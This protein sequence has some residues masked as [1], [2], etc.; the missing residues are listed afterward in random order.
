MH[1]A[2]SSFEEQKDSAKSTPV[3][4]QLPQIALS[5]ADDLA[6]DLVGGKM[7]MLKRVKLNCAN[8]AS[9]NSVQV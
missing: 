3:V 8:E 2:V 1:C 7:D 4:L 9:D 6:I 5:W